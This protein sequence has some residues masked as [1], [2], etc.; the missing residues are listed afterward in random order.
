MGRVSHE[1]EPLR[2]GTLFSIGRTIN[3]YLCTEAKLKQFF[4]FRVVTEKFLNENSKIS[5]TIKI[6]FIDCK[7]LKS[8]IRKVIRKTKKSL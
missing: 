5:L 4:S 8:I 3:S 6:E 2:W 1:K 7:K